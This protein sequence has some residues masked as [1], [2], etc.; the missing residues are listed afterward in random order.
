MENIADKSYGVSRPL[1]V[2][3]K[4]AHVDIIPGIREF[5]A[6]FTHEDTWG[7]GGIL[8]E[9]FNTNARRRKN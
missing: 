4:S 9:R 1:Y 7:P 3:I 2:Y 5:I 8:E 6:E